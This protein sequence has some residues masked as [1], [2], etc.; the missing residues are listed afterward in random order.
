MRDESG[1]QYMRTSGGDESEN[2]KILC[3]Q[4]ECHEVI[5]SE[6][7]KKKNRFGFYFKRR[8]SLTAEPKL[9]YYKDYK[10]NPNMKDIEL[11][12][13]TRLERLDKTKFK[14]SIAHI[15]AQ[16]KVEK[17]YIFRCNDEKQCEDWIFKISNEIDKVKGQST[18]TTAAGSQI[19]K[20]KVAGN[21]S[22]VD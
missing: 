3:S 22:S 7:L 6:N 8:L 18:P 19:L 13:E 4:D 20:A 11:S 21:R 2:P 1:D 14:I 5:I 15:A 17:I 10:E 9:C 12:T 16:K